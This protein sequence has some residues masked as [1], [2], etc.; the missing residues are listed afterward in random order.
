MTNQ[1]APVSALVDLA[2]GTEVPFRNAVGQ[3]QKVAEAMKQ[4][5]GELASAKRTIAVQE[6]DRLAL[7][8]SV[9]SLSHE[10]QQLRAQLAALGGEF[11]EYQRRTVSFVQF[12]ETRCA[13]FVDQEQRVEGAF[14]YQDASRSLGEELRAPSNRLDQFRASFDAPTRSLEPEAPHLQSVFGNNFQNFYLEADVG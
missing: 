11:S 8:A 6:T 5:A 1:G 9:S 10:N 2:K 14:L 13:E 7:Q 4:R 12:V 3:M